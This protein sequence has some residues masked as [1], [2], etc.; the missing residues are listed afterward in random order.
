MMQQTENTIMDIVLSET[1]ILS[2]KSNSLFTDLTLYINELINHHFDELIS[3]LYRL[4]ISEKKLKELL[5]LHASEDAAP[6]IAALIL[7]RQEQKIRSRELFKQ[8][9]NIPEEDKW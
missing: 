3:L 1:N 7:E 4:D 2:L 5:Q 6:I 8:E 9:E